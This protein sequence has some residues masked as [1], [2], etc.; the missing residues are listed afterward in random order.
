MRRSAPLLL[1]SLLTLGLAA[2][3]GSPPTHTP[4]SAPPAGAALTTTPPAP[5]AGAPDAAPSACSPLV[6]LI[7]LDGFRADY[8][9]RTATPTLQRLAEEGVRVQRLIPPYPSLTFPGHATL[10]TGASPP[11]H[12]ILANSFYDRERG[13]YTYNDDVSW[14]EVDP[15]WIH[16]QRHGKRAHVFHWVG[17]SGPREGIETVWRAYDKSITDDQKVDQILAWAQ[18]PE[19]AR[20]ALIMSYF[21]GCDRL[22]HMIGPESPEVTEC[23]AQNDARLGRL[24]EGLGA[25]SVPS[26]LILVSDH[27]MAS[28]QGEVNP[29]LVL[30]EA[31]VEARV[32]FSGSTAQVYLNDPSPENIE[33]A[34][35]AARQAPHT[36]V[37]QPSGASRHPQRSGEIMLQ[38]EP[39]WH[40]NRRLRTVIAPPDAPL[41]PGHHGTDSEDPQMSAIAYLWGAGVRAGVSAQRLRAHD[42]APTAAH[43]L[44]LPPLPAAEGEAA[45]HLLDE[46]R[47]APPSAP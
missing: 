16:T 27:G 15:L 9:E 3:A 1:S 44:G 5:A 13:S 47:C 38:A 39:G 23:I 40:F 41:L 45:L 24:L 43:L 7:S 14:Y 42:I 36:I 19:A 28:T 25:L 2:C 4:P 11:R 33:A 12:G 21:A 6:V 46:A 17:S 26:S 31:G 29:Q 18:A 10:A 20:P 8:P 35:A 22:G 34:L 30:Q 37:T 32:V